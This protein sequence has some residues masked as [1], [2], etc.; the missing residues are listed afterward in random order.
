MSSVSLWL[1]VIGAKCLPVVASDACS[2][3]CS[4]GSAG[5][6][7]SSSY[8]GVVWFA[9]C[10][11]CL[12]AFPSVSDFC[13]VVLQGWETELPSPWLWERVLF[14][15]GGFVTDTVLQQLLLADPKARAAA[16]TACNLDAPTSASV[17]A[18]ASADANVAQLHA[19]EK[20]APDEPAPAAAAT[21]PSATQATAGVASTDSA[22]VE[23][24]PASGAASAAVVSKRL[25][26]GRIKQEAAQG[27]AKNPRMHHQ[28]QQVLRQRRTAPTVTLRRR[29]SGGSVG[30]QKASMR[31][32]SSNSSSSISASHLGSGKAFASVYPTAPIRHQQRQQKLQQPQPERRHHQLLKHR[33][34]I[35]SSS[36]STSSTTSRSSCR[37]SNR[38]RGSLLS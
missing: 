35:N 17:A 10:L 8:L 33:S 3:Y 21:N 1:L 38:R 11:L 5:L 12:D 31:S 6:C 20:Q 32:K 4:L 24:A 14:Y 27:S 25:T 15:C 26:N 29:A 7:N 16:G 30:V 18:A 9:L 28:Q 37:S 34:S 2:P 23:P 22:V 36:S 19:K 13:C